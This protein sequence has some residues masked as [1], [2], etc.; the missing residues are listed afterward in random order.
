MPTTSDQ[1]ETYDSL[2]EAV[3]PYSSPLV[4]RSGSWPRSNATSHVPGPRPKDRLRWFAVLSWP[5]LCVALMV[6]RQVSFH[7]LPWLL[8]AAPL[9]VPLV[10]VAGLLLAAMW[11]DQFS[12]RLNEQ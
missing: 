2:R 3:L 6:T 4:D 1:I 10:A 5:L 8:V 11:L 9:W 7:S 12:S